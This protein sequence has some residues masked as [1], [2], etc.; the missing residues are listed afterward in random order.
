MDEMWNGQPIKHMGSSH[1]INTMS[2]LWRI[3]MHQ[4][5]GLKQQRYAEGQGEGNQWKTVEFDNS[6][7]DQAECERLIK[8]MN[9]ELKSRIAS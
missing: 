2:F 3:V 6:N 1:L 7:F 9:R 4:K 8:I 5:L